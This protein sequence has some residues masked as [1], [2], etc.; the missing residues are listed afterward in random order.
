[1]PSVSTSAVDG[2]IGLEIRQNSED[3]VVPHAQS[4]SGRIS[5][6]ISLAIENLRV[7]MVQIANPPSVGALRRVLTKPTLQEVEMA[8]SKVCSVPD[9]GKP[10]M[11]KGFCNNHYYL[12]KRHGHPLGGRTPPGQTTKF[13]HEVVQKYSGNDCLIWPYAKSR[14]GYGA[15]TVHGRQREVHRYVCELVNGEPP[16]ADHQAAHSCGN[17]GLGCV[18]P[19]HLLW[20]TRKEN[21]T[22]QLVHGTRNHG[23]RNGSAKLTEDMVLDIR[24]D[25]FH[26]MPQTKIASHFG[27][28]LRSVSNI[29]TGKNWK[30]IL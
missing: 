11:A 21:S 22:D 8:K 7:R 19:R 6:A 10:H 15:I 9:C 27:I 24:S 26:G 14:G 18:N 23:S 29:V 12:F 4:M 5:N 30:H 3:D 2:L 25:R 20:K 16:S 17:G 13:L 1:M 28:S